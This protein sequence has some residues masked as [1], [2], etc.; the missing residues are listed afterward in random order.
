MTFDLR[1][2][3]KR[4]VVVCLASAIMAVNIKTFVNTGGLY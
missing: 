2:D 4:I 1:K 3:G